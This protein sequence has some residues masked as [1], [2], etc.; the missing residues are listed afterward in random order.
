MGLWE[1]GGGRA[2]IVAQMLALLCGL[3][4]P[5]GMQKQH[6]PIRAQNRL[7]EMARLQGSHSVMVAVKKEVANQ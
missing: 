7:G 1:H 4:S 5:P 2:G 3:L 6:D